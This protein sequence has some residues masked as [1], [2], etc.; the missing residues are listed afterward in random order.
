M[1]S[2]GQQSAEKIRGVVL[3]V[4]MGKKA[5]AAK[6]FKDTTVY[7]AQRTKVAGTSL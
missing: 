5:G 7:W 2:P 1:L 4:K 3:L 6:D